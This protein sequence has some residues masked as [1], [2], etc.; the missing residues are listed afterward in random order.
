[1]RGKVIRIFGIIFLT[2]TA[3]KIAV[4]SDLFNKKKKFQENSVC[5]KLK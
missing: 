2:S 5:L 3:E 4:V 1:M